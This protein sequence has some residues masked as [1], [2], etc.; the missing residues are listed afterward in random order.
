MADDQKA[1]IDPVAEPEAPM[2]SADQPSAEEAEP[3]SEAQPEQ[4]VGEKTAEPALPQGAKER[5]V[6]EF[7]KL[8]SQLREEKSRRVYLENV[9]KNIKPVETK[10]P[11]LPPVYDPQTGLLDEQAVMERDQ[12]ILEAQQRAARAEQKALDLARQV[13]LREVYTLH[14]EVNPDS[15]SYNQDLD[16]LASGLLYHSAV[17]PERYGGRQLSVADAVARAKKILFKDEK[18]LEV[19]KKEGAT[20]AL[21]KLTPKEQ[22][23]LEA[24][25]TP[26]RRG[27]ALS[28]DE[29][30]Y[31]SRKGDINAVVERLRNLKS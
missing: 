3:Q 12:I 8:R 16:N 7:E 22:A 25:G 21:E 4:K 10:N 27:D 30:K 19:A 26:A 5:T 14:P 1:Q 17:D 23:A 31:R 15:K 9:Y 20:E 18:Q 11:P 2:P 24:T 13:E 29:L 6:R 28:L